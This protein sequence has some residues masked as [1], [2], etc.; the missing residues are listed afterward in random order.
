[1]TTGLLNALSLTLAFP[2]HSPERTQSKPGKQNGAG[3]RDFHAA[4]ADLSGVI[5][6]VLLYAR[7]GEAQ[8]HQKEDH[9]RDFEPQ[10]VHDMA[11]RFRRRAHCAHQR[12]ER[13][14]AA[15]LLAGNAGDD[16]RFSPCGN[17]AH[18]SILSACGARIAAL[19]AVA[20]RSE[21]WGI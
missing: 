2:V 11:E 19:C 6:S 10:H 7:A 5:F 20:N 8:R 17:F 9:S 4:G 16:A 14:A 3:N 1:M 21:F 15:S 12:V 18:T 13:A